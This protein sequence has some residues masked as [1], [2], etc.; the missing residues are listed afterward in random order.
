MSARTLRGVLEGWMRA[1]RIA[2]V[3]IAAKR[4]KYPHQ[5]AYGWF[6]GDFL[7]HRAVVADL[8]KRVGMP[9]AELQSIVSA[10]RK[11]KRQA[12]AKAR[13]EAPVADVASQ[14]GAA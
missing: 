7:P 13:A 12:N 4:L 9:A 10:E 6:N 3:H 5:T 1:K 2:T 11:R 14:G 8:A